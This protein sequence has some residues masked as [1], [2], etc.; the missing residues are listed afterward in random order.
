M[1]QIKAEDVQTI[2]TFLDDHPEYFDCDCGESG[3]YLEHDTNA[4]IH[5]DR[6]AGEHENHIEIVL[7]RLI[8][9]LEQNGP[10]NVRS[11]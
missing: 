3:G 5:T 9:W 11:W 4:Y 8:E 1:A 2:K 6:C 10:I 7:T